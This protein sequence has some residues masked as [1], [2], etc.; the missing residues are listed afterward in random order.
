MALR[1]EA[2]RYGLDSFGLPASKGLVAFVVHAETVRAQVAATGSQGGCTVGATFRDGFL[3]LEDIGLP[4]EARGTNGKSL[5]M[6]EAA[7]PMAVSVVMASA[8]ALRWRVLRRWSCA[9]SR[10]K[11]TT[12][13]AST[14]AI[15]TA[16]TFCHRV[17]AASRPAGSLRW[18]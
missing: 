7:V 10:A 13:R 8:V 9:A 17:I 14:H 6:V 16:H 5:P 15:R 2:A 12:M 1:A 11:T 18:L 4:V 3:F